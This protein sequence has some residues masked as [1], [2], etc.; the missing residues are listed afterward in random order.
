[1]S[2]LLL[3]V[4]RVLPGGERRTRNVW[5]SQAGL[6]RLQ[7]VCDGY[8]GLAAYPVGAVYTTVTTANPGDSLG[9]TWTKMPG[10]G[11]TASVA[12]PHSWRR[13]A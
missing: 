13:T 11:G 5:I 9:G 10:Q 4:E 1:M 6:E 3:S 2:S 12:N 8:P 7:E